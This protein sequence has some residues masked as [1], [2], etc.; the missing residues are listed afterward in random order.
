MTDARPLTLTTDLTQAFEPTVSREWLVTNG[1]GGYAMGT[2]SG[3]NTRAYHGLLIAATD[4][5]VGRTLL[6]EHVDETVRL[7]DTTFRIGR[8]ERAEEHPADTLIE[9]FW[10]DGTMPVWEYRCGTV[11]LEKRLWLQ[12]GSD[13]ALLQYQLLEGEWAEL[14][15]ALAVNERD[16]HDACAAGDDAWLVSERATGIWAVQRPGGHEWFVGHSAGMLTL[17]SA[18]DDGILLRT[19]AERGHRATTARYRLATITVSLDADQPVWIMCAV[20]QPDDV[21]ATAAQS[22]LDFQARERRLIAQAEL[23][24][25]PAAIRQ[26]VLAADQ[27]IVDRTVAD[28]PQAKTVIAGYPWFGDWGRDTMIALPGC[29]W[30]PAATPTPARSCGPSRALSPRA[31]CPTASPMSGPSRSTTPL[32]RH[33][34]TSTPST[35]TPRPAATT[36]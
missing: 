17:N 23:G 34:G 18:W 29:A 13:T 35:P 5:P 7:D 9:R 30:R 19:E 32:T 12:P 11:L 28:E 6:V 15:V 1:R 31:C 27:F 22:L 16:H 14:D 8:T 25:A 26:L 2:V 33:C 3:A 24:D 4:P 21:G 20:N 10:L 36:R